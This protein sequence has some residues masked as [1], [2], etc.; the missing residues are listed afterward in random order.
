ME[1][2]VQLVV[3]LVKLAELLVAL[4]Q[5]VLYFLRFCCAHTPPSLSRKAREVGRYAESITKDRPAT[6][7]A[8]PQPDSCSSF[9]AFRRHK[10]PAV[11]ING[12]R[13]RSPRALRASRASPRVD[14][15]RP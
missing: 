2:I 13:R 7:S 3:L 9:G 8:H 6:R 15:L 10:S 12:A 1:A 14:W 5:E 11:R 4:Q